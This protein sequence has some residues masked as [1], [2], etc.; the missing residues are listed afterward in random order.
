MKLYMFKTVPLSII[1]SFFYCTHSNGICHTG[2]QTACEQNRSW[3]CLRAVR[4]PVSHIPLL[5]VQWKTPDDGQRNC[6]KH[7]EFHSKNKFEKLVHIVGFIIRNLARCTVTWKSN[8]KLYNHSYRKGES[9]VFI[10]HVIV[11]AA[12]MLLKLKPETVK[13][14]NNN[15]EPKR[16]ADQ[17]M[18]QQCCWQPLAGSCQYW[19]YS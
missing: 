3:S 18:I 7:V 15:K 6:S 5:W 11:R 8:A 13:Y 16:N 14:Q 12:I 4:K 9:S 2:L 10:Y 1:R 17:Y 19:S